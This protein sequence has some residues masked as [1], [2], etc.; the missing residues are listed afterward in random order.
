MCL[1]AKIYSYV[2]HISSKAF[3]TD[4][5][6]RVTLV[7]LLQLEHSHFSYSINVVIKYMTNKNEMLLI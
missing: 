6:A 5:A 4:M 3:S 1:M 7:T 2:E